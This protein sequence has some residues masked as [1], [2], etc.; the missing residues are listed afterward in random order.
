MKPDWMN[1]ELAANWMMAEAM[2]PRKHNY[3]NKIN[4]SN[5]ITEIDVAGNQTESTN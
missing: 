5:E 1:G 4:E 3:V 2:K